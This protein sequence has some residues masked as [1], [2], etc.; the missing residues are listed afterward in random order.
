MSKDVAWERVC[1]EHGLKYLTLFGSRAGGR[2]NGLSDWDVAVKFGRKY[3]PEEYL[4]LLAEIIEVVGSDAVDLIVLDDAPP[5][6]LF[7]ALWG[8]SPLCIR[9]H[10][11][12]HWDRVKASAMFSDY[13]VDF[14]RQAREWVRAWLARAS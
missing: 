2:V 10:G 1:S 11:E 5:P 12:Y 13:L 3:A 8:G 6:L 14:G 7:N 9:D 4:G